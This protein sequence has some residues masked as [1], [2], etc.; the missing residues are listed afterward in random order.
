MSDRMSD[1]MPV[2]E[3]QF[4]LDSESELSLVFCHGSGLRPMPHPVE[5]TSKQSCLECHC[6]LL[7]NISQRCTPIQF[8]AESGSLLK[9]IKSAHEVLG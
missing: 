4:D 5:M 2:G 1:E 8:K 6:I 7:H 9:P 3:D